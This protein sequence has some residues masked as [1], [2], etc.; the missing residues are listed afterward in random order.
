MFSVVFTLFCDFVFCRLYPFFP[1]ITIVGLLL[2]RPL[3]YLDYHFIHLDN[4]RKSYLSTLGHRVKN[5]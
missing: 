1:K 4:I 5:L 2:F 3:S